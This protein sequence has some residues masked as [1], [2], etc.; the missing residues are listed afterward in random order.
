MWWGVVRIFRD[1]GYRRL[2]NK[3]RLKFL[4]AEWGPE[5][6][7][8]VLEEEYLGFRLADG[9]AP[10]P[11]RGEA[12]HLGVHLQRDGAY[13]IGGKPPVGRL[14]GDIMLGLAD[15]AESVGS[16]RCAPLPCRTSCCWTCPGTG[17]TTPSP[18]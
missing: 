12:D 14:S 17:S 3:A 11:P 1:Y 13:W 5:R 10:R 9:P 6:F 7:R 2:R 18:D 15:L 16:D 8:E 4:M